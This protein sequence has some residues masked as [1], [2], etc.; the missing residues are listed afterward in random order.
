[1]FLD[2]FEFLAFSPFIISSKKLLLSI[3][4]STGLKE[5]CGRILMVQ[6]SEENCLELLDLA[7]EYNIANLKGR[8]AELFFA[9]RKHVR[10]KAGNG[11]LSE[12]L[13]H[14]PPLA[15]ELLSISL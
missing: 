11:T 2:V 14:V 5:M 15:L 9:H 6:A 4:I 7:C 3:F 13:S 12:T 1:V 8:C 10:E